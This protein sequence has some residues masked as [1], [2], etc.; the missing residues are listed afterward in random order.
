MNRSLQR[1]IRTRAEGRCEYSQSHDE[2]S[3]DPFTVEHIVPL[4]KGGSSEDQNLAWACFGC[5]S[6]KYN[7]TEAIDPVIRATFSLHIPTVY[8]Q[9]ET[10]RGY[11]RIR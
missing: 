7:A 4:S 11:A 3:P 2:Y 10:L 1:R 6:Y 8:T 5:N 9:S